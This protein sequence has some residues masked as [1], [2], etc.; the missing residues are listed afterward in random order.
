MTLEVTHPLLTKGKGSCVTQL[1]QRFY[2]RRRYS[3][4]F[5]IGVI[6]EV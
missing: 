1:N 5:L 2:V 4:I 3:I 6:Q